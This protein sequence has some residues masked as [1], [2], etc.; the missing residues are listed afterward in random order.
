MAF[1]P[2]LARLPSPAAALAARSALSSLHGTRVSTHS[3][4]RSV[5]APWLGRPATAASTTPT[6]A[7]AKG[8]KA[9]AFSAKDQNGN[10]VSLSDFAGKQNVC[11]FFYPKDMTPG[12][13]AQACAFRDATEEFDSLDSAVL[14]VSAGS[15]AQHTQFDQQ[16]KLKFPL[17]VDDD[18][19]LRK[20]FGVPATFGLLPGRVTYV[21][22]KQG[23]VVEVFNSQLNAT[24]HVEVARAALKKMATA[25]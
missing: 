4:R 10:D 7:I 1:V 22:D 24:K 3:N 15:A 20:A 25:K 5:T 16:F 9:P 18:N 23:T 2:T 8:D 21:I 6:M 19:K 17:L 14:G 11:L 12:C 13:T